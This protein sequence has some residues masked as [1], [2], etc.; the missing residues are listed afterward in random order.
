MVKTLRVLLPSAG[1]A[2]PPYVVLAH[3]ADGEPWWLL[4]LYVLAIGLVAAIA[5]KVLRALLGGG[6]VGETILMLIGLVLSG[7]LFGSIAAFVIA[8]FN[9]QLGLMPSALLLGTYSMAVSAVVGYGVFNLSFSVGQTSFFW[10]VRSPL[11]VERSWSLK[12]GSSTRD[13][14]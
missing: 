5:G 12:E 4:L 11:G 1:F 10:G 2:W 14:E 3:R 13:L 8:P 9:G 7:T 6:P